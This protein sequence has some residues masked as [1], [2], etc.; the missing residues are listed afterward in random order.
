MIYQFNKLKPPKFQ[1]GADPLKYEEWK[2]K[3]ENLFEIMKCPNRYKVA[4]TTYQFEGEAEYWWETVKPKGGEDPMTW[5]RL[6]ELLDNKYYARD[7]QRMKEREFLSLKQGQ[8][9]VMEYAARF[10]ELSRFALHQ[11]NTEER[12]MD[13]F[14]QGLR[15]D[16][17]S[18]IAS[19]TF[20][21]F[22]EI[23]QRAVKVARVLDESEKETQALNLE[24]RKRKF[25]RP[26]FQGREDERFRPSYPPGKGKQPMSEP[27]KF[28]P[29]RFCGKY[30]TGPCAF[31]SDRCFECGEK[32]HKW[33]E[34]PKLGRGQDRTLPSTGPPRPPVPARSGGL[35]SSG[36]RQQARAN[37]K[38]QAGGRVYCLEAE[39][40]GDEDPHTVV[41]G[42]FLVN[43][44][45]V[46]VLFDAGATH[47]F[48]NPVIT[49]RMTCDIAELDVCLCVT[50]PIGSL[51]HSELVAKN[52]TIIIQDKLF[53]GDLI[54][55]G[56]RGYD[57]ILARD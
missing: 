28:P 11:V 23:Y 45:P 10:N 20:A 37:K 17:K 40:G 52:C 33:S 18:V 54:L 4:R 29:C 43:T 34:C 48:V 35:P 55:L 8:M 27:P 14:E 5:K 57:V 42:T 9:T 16:I 19:R 49:A 1:G 7:V 26:G 41:S 56:I 24:K 3:L 53:R 50:T 15:G 46:T 30:H 38:P 32:G 13:H 25:T 6:T 12:K 39:E 31:G 44:I 51:Y 21:N 2:R 22:Q 36:P 47:S